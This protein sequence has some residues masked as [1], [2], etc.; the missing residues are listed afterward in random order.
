MEPKTPQLTRGLLDLAHEFVSCLAAAQ[1]MLDPR[2]KSPVNHLMQD[3]FLAHYR[4]LREFFRGGSPKRGPVTNGP[5]ER[6]ADNVW[7]IDYID[8][9]TWDPEPFDKTCGIEVAINKCLSHL[10]YSRDPAL[11]DTEL[12]IGW[13]G[14]L[15]LVGA[16]RALLV[17]WDEFSAHIRHEFAPEFRHRFDTRAE[18]YKLDLPT[19]RRDYESRARRLGHRMDD[20]PNAFLS[21]VAGTRALPTTRPIE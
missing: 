9:V 1:E 14:S 15:H 16:V 20:L 5:G 6:R 10:T 2:H 11:P 8:S 21:P 12:T 3:A 4:A 13:D 19:F 17:A 7:A 18:E